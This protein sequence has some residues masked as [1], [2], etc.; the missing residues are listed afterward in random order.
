[1]HVMVVQCK[2]CIICKP[3]VNYLNTFSRSGSLKARASS[4]L[5]IT[6][7]AATS[8]GVDPRIEGDA[9]KKHLKLL[10]MRNA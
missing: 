9:V 4:L 8:K 3:L 7:A 6:D 5:S 2:L 10:C 1:M